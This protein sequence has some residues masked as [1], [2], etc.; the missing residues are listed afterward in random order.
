MGDRDGIHVGIAQIG[1]GQGGAGH[2]HQAAQVFA[3]GQLRNHAAEGRV[4]CDLRSHH[5]G[6]ELF[7]RT[8]DCRRGLIAGALN[9]QN[10]RAVVHA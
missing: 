8:H 1:F 6:D 3:A 10:Q 9:T 5:A 7:A 4:G 2:R